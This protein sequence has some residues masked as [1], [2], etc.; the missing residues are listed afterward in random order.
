MHLPGWPGS[1]AHLLVRRAAVDQTC[2][3]ATHARW[4]ARTAHLSGRA[5][6]KRTVPP[7]SR[8]S[9][10]GRN[11]ACIGA[12]NRA[13]ANSPP[14]RWQDRLS[15]SARPCRRHPQE[16]PPR[17]RGK[18]LQRREQS[19]ADSKPRDR[20]LHPFRFL[21]KQRGNSAHGH[22]DIH[23]A[24]RA[25]DFAAWARRIEVLTATHL[26]RRRSDRRDLGMIVA[27]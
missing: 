19:R 17:R 10:S 22:H 13:R 24:L 8:E 3:L 27:L 2:A 26:G 20:A 18:L 21:P 23:V 14:A 16:A 11:A 1:A 9:R 4:A 6:T 25:I 7:H 5:I 12:S 15:A